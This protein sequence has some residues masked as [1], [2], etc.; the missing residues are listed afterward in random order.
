MRHIHARGLALTLVATV[1][2]LVS[3]PGEGASPPG[4]TATAARTRIAAPGGRIDVILVLGQS[5]ATGYQ[6]DRATGYPVDP[7]V[8]AWNGTRLVTYAPNAATGVESGKP[9]GYWAA[10]LAYALRY[11]SAHPASRLAVL[12]YTAA[13]T[14]LGC[15]GDAVPDW[16][17]RSRGELLD[18]A[19]AFVRTGLAA[20]RARGYAPRLRLVWW[21]QGEAD[22]TA[23]L[24]PGYR[25]DLAA[26]VGA[27]RD[28]G[29]DFA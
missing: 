13:G 12:R 7:A 4:R 3:R 26:L 21:Q 8:L 28:A 10:E 20:L 2:G 19:R 14:Q 1:A 24:A 15:S 6:F 16:S 18:G 11:R 27:L 29:G 23:A 22:A 17:T 5:N 9:A 25:A